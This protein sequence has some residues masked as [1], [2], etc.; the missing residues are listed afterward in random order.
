MKK[1]VIFSK[2]RYWLKEK[3]I[4]DEQQLV[5]QD[6]NT[7]SNVVESMDVDTTNQMLQATNILDKF[8]ANSIIL[9]E[10]LSLAE[11][12]AAIVKN[13]GKLL[14]AFNNFRNTLKKK[15]AN[16]KKCLLIPNDNL[17]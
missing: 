9:E 7:T 6:E 11:M 3:I 15:L 2:K 1:A 17:L 8:Y 16:N 4:F 14:F 12:Q 13:C 10:E 5:N